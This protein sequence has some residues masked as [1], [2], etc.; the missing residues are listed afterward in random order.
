M[1]VVL[2]GIRPGP[3]IYARVILVFGDLVKSPAAAVTMLLGDAGDGGDPIRR[4]V[5]WPQRE[6]LCAAIRQPYIVQKP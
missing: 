4:M 5:F 2:L 1:R 3:A 6:S